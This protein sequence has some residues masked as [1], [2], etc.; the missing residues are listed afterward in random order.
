MALKTTC[1][2]CPA[3]KIKRLTRKQKRAI[4]EAEIRLNP[5]Y[6]SRR[7]AEQLD[8]LNV[9]DKTV[10]TYRNVMIAKG[11]VEHFEE[12][13]S[14]RG[15][16]RKRTQKPSRNES[17]VY[18]CMRGINADLIAEA[19]KLYLQDGDV[20][21][22]ITAGQGA[23][24]TKV[25]L[26]RFSFYQSDL[27]SKDR[28]YDFTALPYPDE[29]IDAIAFDPPYVPTDEGSEKQQYREQVNKRYSLQRGVN[30]QDILQLYLDG[31]AEIHRTLVCGGIALVK[32]GDFIEDRHQ[33][34]LHQDVY[35]IAMGL[36]FKPVDLFILHRNGSPPSYGS[37]RCARKNHS[38]LYVFK[39]T[40]T[41]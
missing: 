27:N 5:S 13:E 37:Q 14:R 25:D 2:E 19:A 28:Q 33:V 39:K 4:V 17:P 22:D 29:S 6:S 32:I 31:L 41:A 36:N 16:K 23:F 7:I 8:Y 40:A 10:T 11:E 34:F 21:A 15:R 1:K 18:S 35:S 24:W 12:L 3:K 26:S 30:A 20:V 9:S 38:F